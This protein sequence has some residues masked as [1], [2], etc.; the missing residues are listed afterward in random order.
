MWQNKK[1]FKKLAVFQRRAVTQKVDKDTFWSKA[2][3]VKVTYRASYVQISN[4]RLLKRL[5]R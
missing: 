5:K 1:F 2:A 3:L 4:N